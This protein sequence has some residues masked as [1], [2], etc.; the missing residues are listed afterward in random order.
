MVDLSGV[1][2]AE[3]N[4]PLEGGDR[5][6]QGR[7]DHLLELGAGD[8]DLGLDGRQQHGHP[9]LVVERQPLLGLG[10]VDAQAGHGGEGLGVVGIEAS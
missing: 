7:A 1:S 10:A 4:G 6:G 5:L 8:A 9:D 3:R 2:A